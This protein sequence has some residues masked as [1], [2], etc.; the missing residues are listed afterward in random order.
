[1]KIEKQE[2]GWC[3][4]GAPADLQPGLRHSRQEAEENLDV[5][6]R[7]VSHREAYKRKVQWE[8]ERKKR[9]SV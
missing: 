4:V 9:N 7:I 8:A 1:M 3:I 2:G 6:R 5:I